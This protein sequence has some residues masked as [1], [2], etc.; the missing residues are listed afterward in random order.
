MSQQ[1]SKESEEPKEAEVTAQQVKRAR[2]V[3]VYLTVLFVAVL[4]LMVMS[5]FMQQR[6]H[7]AL[8]DITDS[9]SERQTLVELQLKNQDL[10][11]QTQNLQ[12][13]LDGLKEAAATQENRAKAV[14]W[15]RQIETA[16][17]V[18][19]EEAKK[20]VE[21]FKETGLE[22]SLPTESVVEGASS[23]AEDYRNL[24]ATLF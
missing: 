14:E 20:L 6:S 9:M 13:E 19:L 2:P 24:Y 12:K 17:K 23:P 5:F 8:E 18:S 22:K 4:L 16:S 1:E 21:K 7:Q 15:L 3:K 10:T 11:F